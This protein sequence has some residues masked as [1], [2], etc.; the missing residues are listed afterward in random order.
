MD[1]EQ[2]MKKIWESEYFLIVVSVFIAVLLWIYVVYD[3]NPIFETWLRDIPVEYIN[4]SADFESG[5]LV[6]LEGEQKT[7]DL[8]LR[9]RRSALS[10]AKATSVICS[11]DMSAVTKDGTYNIPLTVNTGVDGAE[12]VQKSPYSV[13]LVVDKV[14]TEER[15]VSVTGTGQPKSGYVLSNIESEPQIIKLTGPQSL[16]RNVA[17]ASAVADVTD[18]SEDVTGLYKIKLYDS[19]NKE[20]TDERISKNIE[21]CDVKCRIEYSKTVKVTPLLSAETNDKGETITVSGAAPDSIS[22]V[23]A[24]DKVESINEVYTVET[25]VSKIYEETKKEVRLDLSSLPGGVVV[26]D[27]INKIELTLKPEPDA[28]G[29]TDDSTENNEDSAQEPEDKISE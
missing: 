18:A 12:L 4:Q 11:V 17:D 16:I 23:G 15:R 22:I 3:K 1:G 5:K 25:D 2:K 20:I 29:S 14:V 21:Y 7:A 10:A 6:I 9:G 27:D 24:R 28:S 8:K 26:T 19:N 13:N